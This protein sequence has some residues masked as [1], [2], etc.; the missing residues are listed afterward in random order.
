MSWAKIYFP[1]YDDQVRGFY[2][3]VRRT[4]VAGYKEA[5]R[6]FFQISVPSLH[7]LRDLGIPF[8]IA[9]YLDSAQYVHPNVDHTMEHSPMSWAKI[10]F[11]TEDDEVR[12]FYELVRRTHVVSYREAGRH[13]FQIT[14][15]SMSILRD[16]GIPFEIAGCVNYPRPDHLVER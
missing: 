15:P 8:E 11:P 1:N 7:I 2:E 3:L 5:G 10:Y 13:I 6:Q 4:H 9:G 14:V 16:L 12:G